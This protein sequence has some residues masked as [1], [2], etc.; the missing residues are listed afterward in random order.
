MLS[1]M[2]QAAE[3]M[4]PEVASRYRAERPI[5]PCA[6]AGP[7]GLAEVWVD[8]GLSEVRTPPIGFP[9]VFGSLSSTT[10]AGSRGEAEDKATEQQSD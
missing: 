1:L 2:W 7:E 9:S 10:V 6:R 4:A 8:A 3:A 5:S